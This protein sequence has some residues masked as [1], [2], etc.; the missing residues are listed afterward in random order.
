MK[1]IVYQTINLIN[2]NTYIGVHK[3][4]DPDIFDGY[5]GCGVVVTSPSSYM[6]P[7]TPFQ[8]A[9]KKY[10][11]S[12]FRRTILS[13]FNTQEEAYELESKIVTFDFIKRKDVYNAKIGGFGG[14]SYCINIYQF[15]LKGK[16][17]KKWN[18]SVE[19]ADFYYISDTSISRAS[20][21][22]YACK[23]YY[24]S[25]DSSINL[26]EYSVNNSTP[27]IKCYQYNSD[28]KLVNDYASI[29]EAS[30]ENNVNR[31]LIM[32]AMS[33]GY[34]V[35]EFYYSQ[36]LHENYVGGIKVSLKNKPL[37]V[38]SLKG[39]F[40]IRL[41]NSEE[42][43]EFFNITTTHVI[44]TSI[45]NKKPYKEYQFSLEKFDSLPE[46]INK[47]NIPKKV[48]KYSLTGDLLETFDSATMACK[49]YGISVNRVLKA[50]QKQCKGFIF[51]YI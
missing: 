11:T 16:L 50:Q 12:N 1:Y 45:R 36:T 27:S 4:L 39:E 25:K 40:I 26:N 21:Y 46:V 38:Y 13:I 14:S 47:R 30:K 8:Y 20:K 28:G 3:C 22:K 42:I 33:G 18:S 34:K 24:W 10:G 31:A 37:Y 35:N 44:T 2:N 19:I 48:G 17:L 7:C 43:Y 9:V 41:N 5:I 51:K 23:G 6:N 49:E 15:N 29:F 32:R